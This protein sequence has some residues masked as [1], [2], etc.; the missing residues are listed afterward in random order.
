MVTVVHRPEIGAA[1]DVALLDRAAEPA[2]LFDRL[3]GVRVRDVELADDDLRVDAG[4]VDV[5]R[6]LRRRARPDRG[7]RSA[8]A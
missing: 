5:A 3:L 6:A 1:L 7:W 4:L 8:S 2:R